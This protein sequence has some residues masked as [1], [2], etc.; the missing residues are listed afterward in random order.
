MKGIGE[1]SAPD[2]MINDVVTDSRLA[3][4]GTLF[5][6]IKGDRM[7][8]NDY[9]A[10]ALENGASAVVVQSKADHIGEQI[11]VSDGR[12]A[13]I[14]MAGNYRDGF[15]PVIAAVTGSVGKTTTKEMIA[16]VFSAFGKTLKNEG[17]H[18]NEIGV[19]LTVFGLEPDTELAVIEMGMDRAGDIS[20]LTRAVRPDIAVIT[21]IGVSHIEHLG[22]RENI[23]KAK[24]EITEGL[25]N[26]GI[27][28]I[29]GDDDMLISARA[30]L[31]VKTVDFAI[32]NTDSRVVA[33]DIS[34][35]DFSTEFTIYDKDFGDFRA[36]IPALGEHNIRDAIAAYTVATRLGLN[37]EKAAGALSDYEPTG[38]RQK[39]VD[40]DGITVIEDCYN[41]NPDSMRAALSAVSS[42]P[43]TGIRV[44]VLGDM[45]E[46][47]D[48]SDESHR[49]VGL[50]AR[51]F[52]I[53]VLLCYGENMKYCYSAA[54]AAGVPDVRYFED[55]SEMAKY[56]A[57]TLTGG[58]TVVFKA[59]RGMK[60]EDVIEE[61]YK[62]RNVRNR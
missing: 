1:V 28:V 30:D 50:E 35:R 10:Q 49:T 6:A 40:V 42:V 38:M 9:A 41:A 13:L 14:S 47:G 34:I 55:K 32:K 51:E 61:F 23:L 3:V 8:G 59:S 29:N 26:D 12:S 31:T 22:S 53:D 24:L 27:L 54:I 18:N 45:L 60:L 57:K 46:L 20:K 37:P 48:I 52:G 2:L 5:V 58:D 36:V 44:A 56:L 16:T 43:A 25:K 7:D 21:A 4:E 62:L 39:I 33:K 17:N 15:S 19:P 11:V